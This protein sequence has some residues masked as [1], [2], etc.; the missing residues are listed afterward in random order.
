VA[1]VLV[2]DLSDDTVARLKDRA[3]LRGRSLQQ[4]MKDIFE[5]ASRQGAFEAR[6]VADRIRRQLGAG[7][8]AHG[9][10]VDLIREDRGR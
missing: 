8:R 6:A 5:R 3:R 9:D 4:E 2:R 10:S 7:G 1:Q